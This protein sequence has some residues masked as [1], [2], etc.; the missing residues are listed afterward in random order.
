MKYCTIFLF[1]ILTAC[2]N[3]TPP[4]TD[5]E[6][7]MAEMMG[8]TVE[9]LRKQTPEEHMQMMKNLAGSSHQGHGI[10]T[11]D[12]AETHDPLSTYTLDDLPEVMPTQTV[13]VQDG[14]SI[15]LS[16]TV[17]RK[18][19]G[20]KQF[21]MLG[22]NG[23]IP[24]PIIRSTQGATFTVNVENLTNMPTTI[25]W[26]GLRLDYKND[27]VPTVAIPAIEP[28]ESFAYTVTVP[29][30]GVF[31]YHPHVREDIQQDLGLYGNV[32]VEPRTI[33]AEPVNS[34]KVLVLD[35]ILIEDDAVAPY[36]KNT[37]T[38]PLMGRFGSVLLVNG[39]SVPEFPV[40]KGEIVR[41]FI[42]NVAS[43]RT[44]NVQLPGAKMKRIGGDIGLYQREEWVDSVIVSP[45][46]RVILDVQFT[47][48]GIVLLQNATPNNIASLAKFIVDP[49][50]VDTDYSPIFTDLKVHNDVMADI[51]SFEEEFN[52]PVDKELDITI[53]MTGMDHGN[54]VHDSHDGI[55]WEDTMPAMN[56]MM[57]EDM[58][59]WKFIDMQTKAENMDIQWEFPLNSVQKIR[60]NNRAD[61]A[62]PMQHPVHF[63]GQRFLVL[64]IDGVPTDN[65]VWKDTVLIPAGS[66]ADLLFDMSNPGEWM[67][68]CHIAEHLTNG[69]MGLFRIQ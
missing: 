51:A 44:F 5:A 15:T 43:A 20:G 14:D 59:Q 45:A 62:H 22:Y 55:E 24:G 53:E 25:H 9:E 10:H 21:A 27:G 6:Q 32:I 65:L 68:H 35:D 30:N 64:S 23:Q 48:E 41:L 63:H 28:G 46:E 16:P 8:I 61:S 29:D 66:T 17:V 2:T 57:T 1:I 33:V 13:F 11:G 47:R 52:R 69:M 39:E 4:P 36:G 40:K 60:I 18:T 7:Q 54:M 12:S 26:H 56:A 38:R 19:I 34:E 31:W 49:A 67:F 58:V 37:A 42:T 50:T 3:S